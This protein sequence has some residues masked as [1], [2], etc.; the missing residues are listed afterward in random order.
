MP[1]SVPLSLIRQVQVAAAPGAVSL[2]VGEPSH[3]VPAAVRQ[4]I[5]EA[6]D[7]GDFAYTLNAGRLDL[8]RVLAGRRPHHGGDE[9]STLVTVG[10]QEA[11]ALA[12][13]GLVDAGD[14]VVIPEIAYPSYETLP[15]LVEIMQRLLNGEWKAG[16]Q[17]PSMAYGADFIL[18]FPGV[19]RESV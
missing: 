9:R 13:Y 8:R 1:P 11:L 15:R 10:S 3:A 7:R 17:T 18:Q 2:A 14:E 12:V 16:F 4:A 6:V 19:R 5:R